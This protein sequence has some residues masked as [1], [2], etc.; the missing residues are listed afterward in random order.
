VN[1]EDVSSVWHICFYFVVRG[2]EEDFSG[3]LGKGQSGCFAND[4]SPI[5]VTAAD[6]R[7][8]R[9]AALIHT[10]HLRHFFIPRIR[11]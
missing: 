6:K 5:R 10:P 9:A 1:V 3:R 8:D 4:F 2:N 7:N 11:L